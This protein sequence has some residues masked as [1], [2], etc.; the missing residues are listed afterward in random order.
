MALSARAAE[1]LYTIEEFQQLPEF[2]EGYELVDG[3]LVKKPMPGLEHGVIAD[4]IRDAI[5]AHD[6]RKKLGRAQREVSIDIGIKGNL[7]LPDIS[8]WKAERNLKITKDI[9]P[10]PDL[11]VEVFSPS[12][13][14]GPVALKSAMVKV[15]KL[16]NAGVAIVWVVNPKT[17]TVEVY[18]AGQPDQPTEILGLDGKLDG[19]DVIPGFELEVRDLFEV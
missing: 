3:R 17:R 6:P 13:L 19:A 8:Y 1:K 15:R 12:D 5:M 7:P 10:L 18:R 11:A 14:A 16:I 2:G 9:A 4:N